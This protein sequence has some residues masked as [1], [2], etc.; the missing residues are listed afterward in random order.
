MKGRFFLSR[1]TA[2]R[3]RHIWLAAMA[4]IFT[5]PTFADTAAVTHEVQIGITPVELLSVDSNWKTEGVFLSESGPTV[6][7]ASTTYGVTCTTGGSIIR[8]VL[9]SP[10]PVGATAKMRMQS[11]IGISLGWVTL[12]IDILSDLVL[13][14]K[15]A[16]YNI[17]ELEL[18]VPE[19]ISIGDLR[20]FIVYSIE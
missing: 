6:I 12:A 19:E 5:A 17:A 1:K 14:P 2:R 11:D 9:V 3:I 8:V 16:E 10:F 13:C 20:I 18:T 15:G 4:A 7:I